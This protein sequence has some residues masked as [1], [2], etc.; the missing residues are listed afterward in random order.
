M[1][2]TG[3]RISLS[4]QTSLLDLLALNLHNFEDAVAGIVD[5]ASKEQGMERTLVEL[6]A[7]WGGQ[8]FS[9]GFHPRTKTPMVQPS[10]ELI[11]I[12]ED[13]QV[14]LQNLLTSKYIAHF[15]EE[16]SGWQKKLSTADAVIEVWFEVQRTWSHLE[17][18]DVISTWVKGLVTL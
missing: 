5:R 7:T 15:L 18:S 14:Q 16:V 3:V 4:E 9:Y 2:T 6:D 13:N 10:E 11:E 1:N 17:V 12:L 8:D